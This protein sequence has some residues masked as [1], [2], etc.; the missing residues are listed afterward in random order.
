MSFYRRSDVVY[1]FSASA[2]GRKFFR[3]GGLTFYLQAPLWSSRQL[4]AMSGTGT[5][6]LFDLF[7]EVGIVAALDL[8]QAQGHFVLAAEIASDGQR[9]MAARLIIVHAQLDGVHIRVLDRKSNV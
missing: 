3:L 9:R 5:S 6:C 2:L 8:R 1:G 7:G 4:G